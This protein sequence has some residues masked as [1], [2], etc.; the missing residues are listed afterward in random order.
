[1]RP[2]LH[3]RIANYATGTRHCSGARRCRAPYIGGMPRQA[4]ARS[5][6]ISGDSRPLL[7]RDS[8]VD[9][10][11][12]DSPA[13]A[14]RNAGAPRHGKARPV[15]VVF[16]SIVLLQ[17]LVGVASIDVM[18]AVRA[19][20]GGES[21]YSKGQKDAQLHL[22]NYSD[23]HSDDEYKQFKQ[24]LAFPIGDRIARTALQQ[25]APDAA[26]AR[27][28]LLQGGTSD[29]DIPGVIRLFRVFH[30]TPLMRDA[31]ATWAEGDELVAQLD[32]LMD[33]AHAQVALGNLDS[34][35]VV[36]LRAHADVLNR[37]LT[38]LEARFAKELS[39]GARS[40]QQILL[41]VNAL[42]ASFLG[43][44]GWL[45]IRRSARIQAATEQEVRR[46]QKS[47]QTLLDSAAEGLYGV[48]TRGLCTFINR[49]ALEMLGYQRESEL[50]G[51]SILRIVHSSSGPEAE[52]QHRN[53]AE[54]ELCRR[55]GSSIEVQYWSHPIIENGK[56]T[57]AVTSFFDISARKALERESRAMEAA[58]RENERRM[59]AVVDAVNDAVVTID[60]DDKVVL[61]NGAAERLFCWTA[62]EILGR[63]IGRLIPAT[64]VRPKSAVNRLDASLGR[65]VELVGV[66]SD[67]YELALEA[68]VSRVATHAGPLLTAV[69]RDSR[70]IQDARAE[71]QAREA[72]EASN[73][74]KTEFLSRMS[75]ELRTPLN[76]VL[77]FARLLLTDTTAALSARQSQRISQIEHAGAHLLALVNDV[78]DLSRVESGNMSVR[79]EPIDLRAAVE[80]AVSIV[81]ATAA[82]YRVHVVVGGRLDDFFSTM[83][84][85]QSGRIGVLADR[86]RL[87]QVLVNLLTNG[88]K[89]NRPG[90]QVVVSWEVCGSTVQTRI[91]DDGPGIPADKLQRLFQPFNRLGA[92]NSAV[93]GTGIG[94]VL[95]RGLVELMSGN[96]RIESVVGK[97]CEAYFS[98]QCVDLEEEA[99]TTSA[100]SQHGALDEALR[101]LYAEDNEVNVEVVRGVM[102]LRP[103]VELEIATSGAAAFLKAKTQQPHLMLVD[104]HLGDM[105]GIEL[106]A[107]LKS[108]PSTSSIPLV[109]LSADA[110]PEQIS[111]AMARGFDGYLTK[112]VDFVELLRVIDSAQEAV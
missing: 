43:L 87:N 78:L 52:I 47:L 28:G 57:G 93:E 50:R 76:A 41:S 24:A 18:A 60:A 31:V 79:L 44:S 10:Q 98:L 56:V 90:G 63:D 95:T 80:D 15:L 68:S 55:D 66:R 5:S 86:V 88:I 49:A 25:A 101:V 104:M 107:A 11:Q 22:I 8:S 29:D 73:R 106:A 45:F 62:S 74:A 91:E 16:G 64:T 27:L 19:Y 75:H 51:R 105:S 112:P 14:A 67:G 103:S 12:V 38:A 96:L 110:L 32:A 23:S 39:D 81:D 61:F 71:R 53:A 69:L 58:L 34:P 40:T 54:L 13:T 9:A 42:L 6:P 70:D 30:D 102:Q 17:L 59:S 20:V 111:T 92:E 89:Y 84:L 37:S 33:A 85:S 77:G 35:A 46:R 2:R 4:A 48:D 109:A 36:D 72:L 83:G 94:L 100:P 7:L 3:A 65:L 21:L 26:T 99:S 108:D 97:G 1:M 82:R